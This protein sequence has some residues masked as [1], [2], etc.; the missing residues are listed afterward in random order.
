MS[1]KFVFIL[2]FGLPAVS[3]AASMLTFINDVTGYFADLIPIFLSLMIVVFFWGVVKF[4]Y[5]ADDEKAVA[6]GKSIMIWGV[7]GIGVVALLWGIVG[8]LQVS[9][10][11]NTTT[12]VG[13][14]PQI[15]TNIP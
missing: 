2:L 13:N 5:H 11:L 6:E 14:G 7:V 9:L 8:Y 12:T 15:V 3:S 4:I 1:K 10:G